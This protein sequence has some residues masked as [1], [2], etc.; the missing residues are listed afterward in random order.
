MAA[1]RHLGFGETGNSAIRSADLKNPTLAP[2]MRWIGWSVTEIW[3]F[4]IFQ[5]VRSVGQSVGRSLV[6]R[7]SSVYTLFLCTPLR[8]IRNVAHEEVI[9]TTVLSECYWKSLLTQLWKF[10]GNF[11]WQDF[12]PDNS[13]ISMTFSQ[14]PDTS[15][16][17]DIF[18][19]SGFPDKWSPWIRPGNLPQ[20]KFGED[21]ISGGFWVN[22]WNIWSFVT[23]FFP[24]R[25]G[26]HTTKP[27]F[28]QNGLNDLD[29]CI[30]VCFAVKIQTFSNPW[31]QAPKATKIWPFLRLRKFSPLTWAECYFCG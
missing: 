10:L 12:F 28:M 11:P 5:N 24:Y 14:T 18:R 4:E 13:D 20:N 26:G 8:Y 22:M 31:P 7:R 6:S 16:T 15:L 17:P 23:L 21:R 2:N 29:S 27:I 25:P 30:V 9:S 19:F 3:P 1:S